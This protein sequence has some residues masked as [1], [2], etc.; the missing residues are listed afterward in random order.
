MRDAFAAV[1][2]DAQLQICRFHI[3]KNVLLQAK[4]KGRWP[5][6]PPPLTTP[7]AVKKSVNYAR[8]SSPTMTA[9]LLP[10]TTP[11]NAHNYG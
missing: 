1:Y 4:K 6:P 7:L 2:P 3:H 10:L 11:L 5:R 8:C 9:L